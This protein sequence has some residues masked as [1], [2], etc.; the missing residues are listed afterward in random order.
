MRRQTQ[1]HMIRLC[2]GEK[3]TSHLRIGNSRHMIR[4]HDFTIIL[5]CS[6]KLVT[7]NNIRIK[8]LTMY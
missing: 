6:I 4:T 5:E 7:C 2:K 8:D 3:K 1:D